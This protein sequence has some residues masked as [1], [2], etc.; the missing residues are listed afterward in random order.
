[1]NYFIISNLLSFNKVLFLQDNE[2]SG[3]IPTK[4]NQLSNLEDVDFSG[5]KLEGELLIVDFVNLSKLGYLK[6]SFNYLTGT[7]PEEIFQ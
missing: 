3:S 7:I 2:F 6:L 1:M 4:L 5:N